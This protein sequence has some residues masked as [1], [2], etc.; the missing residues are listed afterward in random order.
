MYI[1]ISR[2]SYTSPYRRLAAS[3]PSNIHSVSSQIL[4]AG[5]NVVSPQLRHPGFP[6]VLCDY[7]ARI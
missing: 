3:A 1:Q 4:V 7:M 5:V 6:T 2:L